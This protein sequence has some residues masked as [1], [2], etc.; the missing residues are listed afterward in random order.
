M[1]TSLT[2]F[3]LLAPSFVLA[4]A[5]SGAQ[6]SFPL[7]LAT[8]Q[9]QGEGLL[10]ILRSRIV[11]EPFNIVVSL[12]FLCAIIHALLANKITQVSRRIAKRHKAKH[13]KEGHNVSI[14]SE[15]LHFFGEVEAVFGIW[16]LVLAV[17]FIL[18]KGWHSFVEYISNVNY[19]EPV[20][21]VVIMALAATKPIISFAENNLKFVASLFGGGTA[22][23]WFCILT[24][25]PLLGSFITEPAAMT[26][27]A[28][29]LG[30]QFY[31]K[32]PSRNFAYAT[33]GL[34]FVNISVGGTLTHFAAPPVL[35]VANIWNWGSIYMATN[36]GWKAILGI[37]T[38]NI[39]YFLIFRKEFKKMSA[40]SEA[41][42]TVRSPFIITL[43]HILFIVWTVFTSHH[44]PLFTGGFLFFLAFAVATKEFQAEINLKSPLLV[45]FFLSGLVIHG[46]LQGWWLVPILTRLTE[47]Q[48]FFSAMLLTAF[49]DNAAITYL[50]SLVPNFADTMKYA[51]LAGAL[52]GGGLTVIANAP[53][54]AGQSILSKYFKNGV[55]PV[56][57]M[58]GAILPTLVVS[59]YFLVFS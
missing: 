45:G 46:G 8:Y 16:V 7:S 36:F 37:L 30:K 39:I 25:A 20:F 19:T 42:I 27:A 55:S 53:N 3:L 4:T 26:I 49:N 28:L 10:E 57:L 58:L 33:I 32:K 34:L 17:F 35:I 1:K 29:L 12:I 6:L 21:V 9:D 52:A 18:S 15:F 13:F 47:T 51:V 56:G 54:P 2:L 41:D 44:I 22:A 31:D 50:S 43:I 23:Y 48:L 59:F 40:V 24:V 11:F 5:Q 14:L 38:S